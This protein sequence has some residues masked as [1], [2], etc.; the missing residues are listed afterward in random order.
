M[1][2]I[3]LGHLKMAGA[4]SLSGK[5]LVDVSNPLD[6]SKGMPPALLP[7]MNN[8]N[9]LGEEIQKAFPD[10]KVVKTFNTM[11]CGL[12]VNPGLLGN[13]DHINYIS[14]NDDNAKA[15]VKKL[16]IKMGWKEENLLDLGD[17]TA[18]RATESFLHL[19]LRVM[20]VLKNGTFNFKLVK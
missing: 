14:G 7:G 6:F 15:T 3:Q 18:A 1:A 4:K 17:I 10:T 12:M 20:G 8:T 13:G 5:I 9:S 16:L 19:W 2:E 11:W